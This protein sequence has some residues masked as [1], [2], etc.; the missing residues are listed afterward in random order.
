MIISREIFTKTEKERI[1]LIITIQRRQN[2]GGALFDKGPVRRS[3]K[4]N[5]TVKNLNGVIVFNME[6][7]YV[8]KLTTTESEKRGEPFL[9]LGRGYFLVGESLPYAQEWCINIRSRTK[10]LWETFFRTKKLVA[11]AHQ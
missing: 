6:F 5:T 9:M 1:L 4:R 10:K 3:R 8:K 2:A 11:L 7:I